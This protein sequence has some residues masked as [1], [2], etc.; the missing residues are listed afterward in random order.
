[1]RSRA[2][3]SAQEERR[4]GNRTTQLFRLQNRTVM[5]GADHSDWQALYFS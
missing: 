3:Q 1:M 2:G 4:K 5:A